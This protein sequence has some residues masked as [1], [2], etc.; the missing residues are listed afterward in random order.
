MSSF[1][2]GAKKIFLTFP[3]LS[4]WQMTHNWRQ[5]SFNNTVTVSFAHFV[6]KFLAALTS[7][8]LCTLFTFK[9]FLRTKFVWRW[10]YR[11]YF[12]SDWCRFKNGLTVTDYCQ[13]WF[14]TFSTI[15]KILVFINHLVAK[16]YCSFQRSVALEPV[17]F[18][19]AR[20]F[21]YIFNL[22]PDST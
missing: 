19:T 6:T 20:S 2:Y 1:M 10:L 22:K 5:L 4:R 17:S 7:F 9:K 18:S 15:L 3:E 14:C 12:R 13:S 21:S 11:S 8:F 16:M